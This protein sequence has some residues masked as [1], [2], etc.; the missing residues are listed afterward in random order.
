MIANTMS[1]NRISSHT[2]LLSDITADM[3]KE[4]L[5]TLYFAVIARNYQKMN[6]LQYK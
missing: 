4:R 2:I 3:E 6:I 1:Y 5:E